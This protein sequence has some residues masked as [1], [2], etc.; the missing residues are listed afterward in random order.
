MPYT[1]TVE[2]EFN[3]L[4]SEQ[5]NTVLELMILLNQK[6]GTEDKPK[7]KRVLYGIYEGDLKYI[8][9]DFDEAPEGFEEYM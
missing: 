3:S 7:K 1:G 2:K 4:T 5:Q 9:D 8:S 6:N